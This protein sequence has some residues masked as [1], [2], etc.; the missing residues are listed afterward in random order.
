MVL[1]DG[2]PLLPAE[3]ARAPGV[4]QHRELPPPPP[5]YGK[6]HVVAVLGFLGFA[7]VYAMRVNLSVAALEMSIEY[8]WCG[9]NATKGAL[10]RQLT[11]CLCR[12]RVCLFSD[13]N[14]VM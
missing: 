7:N 11:L 10:V 14:C 13:S 2:A 12:Y 6:R 3:R 1:H 8:N 5:C 9:A 4:R